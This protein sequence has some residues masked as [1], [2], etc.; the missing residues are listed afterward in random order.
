MANSEKDKRSKNF[1]S[2]SYGERRKKRHRKG[3]TRMNILMVLL[4]LIVLVWI[5]LPHPTGEPPPSEFDERT[6]EFP[7]VETTI[8]GPGGASEETRTA[9]A[10]PP[11]DMVPNPFLEA[12]IDQEL[13]AGP[14]RFEIT[15][16]NKEAG[17]KEQADG[18]HLFRL[19]GRLYLTAAEEEMPVEEEAADLTFRV[20]FFSNKTEEYEKFQPIFTEDLSFQVEGD[21]YVFQLSHPEDLTPGLYYYFIESSE[22]GE[23]FFVDKVVVTNG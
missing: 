16:P 4:V 9:A 18:T 1:Y 13:R 8:P 20:Q 17:L 7:E 11:E 15:Y 5:F 3:Q 23:I 2:T 22:N 6:R 21:H 10:I 12:Y 19:A 14:Y